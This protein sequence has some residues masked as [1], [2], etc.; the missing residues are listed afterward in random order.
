MVARRA[1]DG[2]NVDGGHADSPSRKVG[3][4]PMN[5]L[6]YPALDP[7]ELEV[8]FFQ[9]NDARPGEGRRYENGMHSSSHFPTCLFP[10]IGHKVGG[11]D[12]QSDIAY[13]YT[14]F[15]VLIPLPR[16]LTY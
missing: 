16:L 3:P 8:R 10:I 6:A 4:V 13:M 9:K 12:D 15:C 14:R 11:A 5:L 2:I 7:D 1:R